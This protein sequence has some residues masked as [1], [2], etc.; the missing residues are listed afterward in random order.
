MIYK[1]GKHTP[2]AIK[3][4]NGQDNRSET[5]KMKIVKIKAIQI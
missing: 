3:K 1:N 4:L 2:G 5:Q